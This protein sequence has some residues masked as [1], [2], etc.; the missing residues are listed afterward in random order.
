MREVD[1]WEP[2]RRAVPAAEALAL[3]SDGNGVGNLG[4]RISPRGQPVPSAGEP[5][6]IDG[7]SCLETH[8]LVAGY[9]LVDAGNVYIAA[10]DAFLIGSAV[11][12]VAWLSRTENGDDFFRKLQDLGLA[13]V[14]KWP[15]TQVARIE[16]DRTKKYFKLWDA[17]LR[18]E[19]RDRRALLRSQIVKYH[20]RERSGPAASEM[21]ALGRALA[22]VVGAARGNAVQ[23]VTE[24]DRSGESHAVSFE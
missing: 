10:T 21:F 11:S 16:I 8:L 13:T 12:G 2:L 14:F 18:I 3:P 23:W 17:E 24:C 19:G 15:L 1:H 5:F 22:D 6:V 9:E 4:I 20:G 7:W